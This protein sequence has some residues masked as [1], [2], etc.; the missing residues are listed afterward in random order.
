M[1]DLFSKVFEEKMQD[2]TVEKIVSEKLD[3]AIQDAIDNQFSWNS[4]CRKLLDG[5]IKE[6]MLPCL[7]T[8]DWNKFL[9]KLDIVLT[10]IANQCR[11]HEYKNI[12]KNF[13][14]L[15]NPMFSEK[16]V[17]SLED[18]GKIYAKYASKEVDASKLGIDYDDGVNYQD[19]TINIFFEEMERP[20]W[21]R[22]DIGTIT[23]ECEEDED[24]NFGF[25]VEKW[26]R[27][28]KW[29]MSRSSLRADIRSIANMSEL[30]LMVENLCY[31]DCR[32][33]LENDSY[34]YDA[35]EVEAEPEASFN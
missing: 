7:E 26:G 9:P 31:A 5:K 27:S 15:N 28:E 24:L 34:T 11:T 6:A 17:L 32:L 23:F 21:S 33:D 19:L 8:H 2:G 12:V 4:D 25:E 35:V 30:Q 29:E 16:Q 14:K 22:M 18:L 1:K 3:K 20:K 10:Q 13:E